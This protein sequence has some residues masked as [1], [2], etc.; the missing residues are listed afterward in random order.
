[1]ALI[2]RILLIA[3]AGFIIILIVAQTAS[4]FLLRPVLERE[5][6]RIFKV[7]VHVDSAGANLFRASFWM[8]GVGL[9][10]APGFSEPYALSARTISVDL[11]LLSFLTSQFVV[12]R[13]L[14]KDPQFLFE[15]NPK[16]E[17]NF[18]FFANRVLEH[19]NRFQ[20]KRPR[21]I[22]L[23]TSY[24]LEKFAVRNGDF[25]LIDHSEPKRKW[26][27][28]SISFSLARVVHPADPEDIMPTAI[29]M[30]ATVPGKQEGQV[31]VL[32]RIN[33][34][35]LK[36]SFD[37]TASARNLIFDQYSG[38][39][40]NFPLNFKE[41]TLHL[42]IKAVCHE[43][44]VEI[45]HQVKIEKLKFSLKPT[46]QK[47]PPTI[48]GL[49]STTIAHFFNQVQ[50]DQ[51][52]F[53]FEFRISGNLEDPNFNIWKATEEKLQKVISE[54]VTKEMKALEDEARS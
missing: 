12:T 39:I 42:K 3:V 43:N 38:L 14:L 16:G 27:L 28:R 24:T 25:Q 45:H 18:T 37:I 32:G 31:L 44:Q 51:K 8:K 5:I 49:P 7:P 47:K 20:L 48:F 1:M 54:R 10:N 22:H 9:K 4:T 15:I 6:R 21:L 29:Y 34:F 19:F 36:K 13:L 50:P 46:D 26:T 41:G 23:I 52:P 30:N 53:E 11:S 17:S 35:A 40:P 33:P 2:K